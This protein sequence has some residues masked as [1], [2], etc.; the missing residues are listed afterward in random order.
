MDLCCW[1]AP[2]L[3]ERRRAGQEEWKK[4]KWRRKGKAE[5][6]DGGVW[7]GRPIPAASSSFCTTPTQTRRR[8]QRHTHSPADKAD[9]KPQTADRISKG[10]VN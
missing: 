3:M 4:R 2:A 7:A 10:L 8:T 9:R 5:T 6:E 1:A